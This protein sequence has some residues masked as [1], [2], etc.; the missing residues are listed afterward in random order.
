MN[1]KI[2][3][4]FCF[5]L[6]TTLAKANENLL[7][8]GYNQNSSDFFVDADSEIKPDGVFIGFSTQIYD[9]TALTLSYSDFQGDT[10]TTFFE[11][12]ATRIVN[13]GKVE[14]KSFGISFSWLSENY[15]LT[16]SYG[17]LDNNESS[18][19][20]LPLIVE[21]VEGDDK[22]LS[23]SYDRFFSKNDW[24][25]GWSLGTQYALSD[26]QVHDLIGNDPFIEI[27]GQF[28]SKSWSVFTDIDISLRFKSDSM[29]ISPRL[30]LSW[31]W[32]ISNTGDELIIISREGLRR[33]FNQLNDQQNTTFRT[34]DSGFWELGVDFDWDN[35]G[36]SLGYGQSIAADQDVDSISFN[37][38]LSF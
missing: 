4:F 25:L 13:S 6:T 2:T 35:W 24:G 20:R 8:I 33:T 37:I 9:N 3:L 11:N 7:W 17:Q 38:N 29:V 12:N 18:L 31:N 21:D 30:S 14:S 28:D 15:G 1:K 27:D 16:L 26:V 36:A 34:P 5:L 32:E 23:L 19:T 22:I 10:S